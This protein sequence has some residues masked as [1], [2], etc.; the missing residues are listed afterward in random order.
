MPVERDRERKREYPEDEL[1]LIKRSRMKR[2]VGER[3]DIHWT[4]ALEMLGI[5]RYW[6]L[7]L[8]RLKRGREGGEKAED[9]NRLHKAVYGVC[10]SEEMEVVLRARS[11][12]WLVLFRKWRYLSK[13]KDL[14]GYSVLSMAIHYQE[15]DAFLT[16]VLDS[17]GEG[18]DGCVL[19]ALLKP[20]VGD[21]V[22]MSQP[23]V[24]EKM[25]AKGEKQVPCYGFKPLP[26][27]AT[28]TRKKSKKRPTRKPR[29]YNQAQG[30][31][32][33]GGIHIPC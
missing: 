14:K 7:F 15:L 31:P 12:L 10:L 2:E 24:G 17:A 5:A 21:T 33:Q 6:A 20:E 19:D 1:P 23:L 22:F 8:D 27:P 3:N 28:G 26:P 18:G 4:N 13:S 11:M 16:R 9:L 29:P 25:V 30:V 32:S